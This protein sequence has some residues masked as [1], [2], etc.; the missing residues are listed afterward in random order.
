MA[1]D[2]DE[3]SID[4]KTKTVGKFTIVVE[5]ND[6]SMASLR[7]SFCTFL[8]FKQTYPNWYNYARKLTFVK[9][10]TGLT[11]FRVAP[12]LRFSKIANA[13]AENKQLNVKSLRFYHDGVRI[14]EDKSMAE[15]CFFSHPLFVRLSPSFLFLPSTKTSKSVEQI[16]CYSQCYI[17]L[18]KGL[19]DLLI[20]TIIMSKIARTCA[21][22]RG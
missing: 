20:S 17:H 13:Y 6:K 16:T 7:L 4:I 10:G 21:R 1:T 18:K 12:K 15:V 2:S 22:R 11:K 5:A 19:F 14:E 9:L 3:A 8:Y